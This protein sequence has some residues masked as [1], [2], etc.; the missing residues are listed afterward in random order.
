VADQKGIGDF[1]KPYIK[2]VSV[3]QMMVDPSYQRPLRR[4]RVAQMAKEFDPYKIGT[5]HLSLRDNGFFYIMDGQHRVETLREVGWGDQEVPDCQVYEGLTVEQEAKIWGALNTFVSPTP[6]ARF[7][8]DVVANK[9]EAVAI[10][11]VVKRLGLDIKNSTTADSLT[12]VSAMRH[13]HQ[14]GGEALIERV[15][16][17]L[18]YGFSEAWGSQ[19]FR[20]EFVLGMAAFLRAHPEVDD[21]RVRAVLGKSRPDDLSAKASAS[22]AASGGSQ[23]NHMA[24]VLAGSYNNRLREGRIEPKTV[25]N[26]GDGMRVT[27]KATPN[28]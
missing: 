7:R 15:L 8:A 3:T 22:K 5:L 28:K 26:Y 27:G 20:A 18:V 13:L 16:S 23:F 4:D 2:D 25:R 10:Q 12:C 9:P 21:A 17:N 19:R 24:V 14:V 11:S 1:P 6:L